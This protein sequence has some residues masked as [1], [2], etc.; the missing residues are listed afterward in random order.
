MTVRRGK[1]TV[2]G[3][4]H[5]KYPDVSQLIKQKETHRRALASLSFEEKIEM[6][7]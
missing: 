1:I 2:I 7:F 6:V 4:T 3:S 5:K